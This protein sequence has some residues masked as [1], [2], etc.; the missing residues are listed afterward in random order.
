MSSSVASNIIS[1]IDNEIDSI[2]VDSG[3]AELSQAEIT[4]LNDTSS[5]LSGSYE[6]AAMQRIGVEIQRETATVKTVEDSDTGGIKIGP[7]TLLGDEATVA[8]FDS[9]RQGKNVID[10]V[11]FG[12]MNVPL[13]SVNREGFLTEKNRIKHNVAFNNYGISKLF[14]SYDKI[15]RKAIP[16]EDFPGRLIPKD[17]VSAGDYILQY[18][19]LTDLTRDIDKFTNPDDLNG[20][21]EVFEIRESFANTSISDIRVRGC[22]GSLPNENFYAQGQ[23][24]SPIDNKFE[25]NQTSNSI[26]EDSQDVIYGGVTFDPKEGYVN[27][28]SFAFESP[29]ADE[30]RTMSPYSESS[31]DRKISFS[32]RLRDFIGT[33]YSGD[34]ASEREVPDLGTRNRSSQSGFIRSPNYAIISESRF[35]NPGTESIAFISTNRN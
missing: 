29:V 17:F 3:G 20:A 22:K 34:I 26:F 4:V 24:A 16:F 21:I 10:L 7:V 14:K 19:I 13:V 23:G 9:N 12:R 2:Y 1:N 25:I 15:T 27:S 28:G 8:D 6:T 5:P 30:N 32:S 31:S 35:I 18:M 33:D 11:H